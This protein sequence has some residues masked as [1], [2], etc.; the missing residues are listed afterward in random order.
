MENYTFIDRLSHAWNAFRDRE[1][2]EEYVAPTQGGGYSYRPDQ[3]YYYVQND[4][5]I[6]GSI[7]NRLSIDVAA[8]DFRHIK[9]DE[10]EFFKENVL[11]T[12]DYCLTT[13]ANI[14][15][16]GRELIGNIAM[17]LF[18]DGYC[19]VVPVD[20]SINPK[21]SGGYNILTLRVGKIVQWYP[22]YVRVDLYDDRTSMHKQIL[23][24][25]R[26]VAIITNPLYSVMNKPNS[27]LQRLIHK[28]HLLDVIDSQSGSGKLDLIIQLPYVIK[29]KARQ[30]Q[31]EQRRKDI[32][33]QLKDSKYGIAY[34]DGTE[35]ITQLNRPAENNLMSQIEY[36]TR[37]VYSQLGINEAIFNGTAT[38]E[39]ML[40]YYNRTI[41]PVCTAIVEEFRRKFLTKTA[42]T[43]G[44]TIQFF[45]NPFKLVPVNK[46][47]EIADKFTRNEILSPNEIRAVVGYKPSSDPHA[48]ELRNRNISAAKE[49]SATEEPEDTNNPEEKEDK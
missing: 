46:I 6:V 21:E 30:E 10:N 9:E 41:E 32:E 45:R 36:L 13:E 47:A 7:Y 18:T 38:E 31:A 3:R 16:T 39:E 2:I 40:N 20:T 27:T 5:S 26:Q 12:L 34:T 29:S 48:D 42:R 4:K 8:L 43:Q 1:V 15:Q 17:S 44:Q 22:E 11:S 49:D 19:A 14:D 28:L 33:F 25:K 24:P 23:L 35:R 37:M